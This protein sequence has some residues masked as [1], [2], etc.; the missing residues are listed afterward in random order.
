MKTQLL[1][2]NEMDKKVIYV[3]QVLNEFGDEVGTDRIIPVDQINYIKVDRIL[4]QVK[5]PEEEE[6]QD[7]ENENVPTSEES[8]TQ[9]TQQTEEITESEVKESETE[10]SESE[11]ASTTESESEEGMPAYLITFFCK[12]ERIEFFT[13][14]EEGIGWLEQMA[15]LNGLDVT[16]ART[17]EGSLSII[18]FNSENI[19]TVQLTEA[20]SEDGKPLLVIG[21]IFPDPTV[22]NQTLSLQKLHFSYLVPEHLTEETS[23]TLYTEWLENLKSN[24]KKMREGYKS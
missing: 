17:H 19:S 16:S 1:K 10:I 3:S 22:L 6:K 5:S 15:L 13:S 9:E 24:S 11:T 2:D 8:Q 14:K 21:M 12:S 7:L 20:T 18:F 4:L 23:Y